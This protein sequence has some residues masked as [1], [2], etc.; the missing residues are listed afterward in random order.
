[1]QVVLEHHTSYGL[2]LFE[3]SVADYQ[4]CYMFQEPGTVQ[5]PH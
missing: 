4:Q 1:M 3:F 2:G 5:S